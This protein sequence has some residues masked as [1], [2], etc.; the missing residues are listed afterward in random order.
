[1]HIIALFNRHPAELT[2][3]GRLREDLFY[4]LNEISIELPP[5]R[6]RTG[7]IPLLV[8][9]CI[10]DCNHRFGLEI[11]RVSDVV[12]KHLLEHPWRGNVRELLSLVRRGALTAQERKIIW[13]EDIAHKV[14]L[15]RPGPGP[16]T[17]D[18]S[19]SAAERR[20]I[21][22]VLSLTGGNKRQAAGLLKIS[23]PTLDKKIQDYQILCRK[24]SLHST[25]DGQ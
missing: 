16:G 12:M 20:Q 7:D 3:E 5:L 25:D 24:K 23:R 11:E 4:R 6:Q 9:T 2:A 15:S 14:E 10:D 1:M 13:I 17:S 21:E 8:Q 22:H 19:L 18:L